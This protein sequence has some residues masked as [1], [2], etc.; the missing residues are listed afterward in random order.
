MFHLVPST[1]LINSLFI[2]SA[3]T[4]TLSSV[5]TNSISAVKK[6]K[7]VNKSK[8]ALIVQAEEGQGTITITI[9]TAAPSLK[10]SLHHAIFDVFSLILGLSDAQLLRWFFSLP[11]SKGVPG[12]KSRTRAQATIFF[13]T[14]YYGASEP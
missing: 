11:V 5:V 2:L 8:L 6:S 14:L 10:D 3:K 13:G 12:S 1:S 7:S 4:I 9:A